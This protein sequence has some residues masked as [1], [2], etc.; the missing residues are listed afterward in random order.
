MPD[1]WK[2]GGRGGGVWRGGGGSCL[3][4]KPSQLHGPEGSAAQVVK[5]YGILLYL[6]V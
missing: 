3:K 4:N 1:T 6:P 5:M 2:E